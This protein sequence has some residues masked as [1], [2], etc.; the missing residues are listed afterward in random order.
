MWTKVWPA[1]VTVRMHRPKNNN[2]TA[3]TAN[4]HIIS[5]ET[6]PFNLNSHEDNR[7]EIF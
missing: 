4:R 6:L 7:K 3:A 2:R 1:Y 5:T